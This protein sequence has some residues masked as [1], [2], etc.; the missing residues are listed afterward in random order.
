MKSLFTVLAVFTLSMAMNAQQIEPTIE[1]D[2]NLVKGTFY[3][4]NGE[5]AQTGFFKDGK[6][7]GEWLAFDVDGNKVARREFADG[8]RTGTWYFWK[9]NG[10]AF[11]EVT[12]ADG[13]LLEVKVWNNARVAR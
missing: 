1:N 10:D 11:R 4:D 2:G 13:R 5:V 3:H 6:V 9:S 12:Y 7:D 8:I